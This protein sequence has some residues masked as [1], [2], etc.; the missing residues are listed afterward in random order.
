[1]KRGLVWLMAVTVAAT[2]CS[3]VAPLDEVTTQRIEIVSLDFPGRLW[4]PLLPEVDDGRAV[5]IHGVLT[6]PPT[7]RPVPAVVIAHGCGGPGAGERDWAADLADSGIASLLLDSFTGR[8]ITEMCSGRETMNVAG[9]VVDAYRA[10]DA[11]ADNPRIDPSRVAVMGFSFGGRTALWSSFTRFQQTYRG[12]PFR[13]Y[14]AFYPST[15]FIR[16]EDERVEGG[17]IRILHGTADDWT[18]LEPCQEFVDRLTAAEV[19]AL[20]LPYEGAH[21]SFDNRALGWAE[22]HVGPR[23]P[24]PRGCSFREIDGVIVDPDTGGIAGVGSPCVQLGVSYAF[25]AAARDRAR[26]DLIDFLTEV[27]E[28]G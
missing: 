4:D 9:V 10:F 12:D 6:I 14:V 1:M 28:V 21:H 24:S 11:I 18:P 19:D 5:T 27:L 15:C 22:V 2:G 25:D 7:D 8:G 23:I 16:L 17:P 26:T 20:L 3:G 13:G